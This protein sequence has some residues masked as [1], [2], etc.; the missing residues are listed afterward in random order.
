MIMLLDVIADRPASQKLTRTSPL[1][2]VPR[3][4]NRASTDWNAIREIGIVGGDPDD[5]VTASVLKLS[6]WNSE[7]TSSVQSAVDI[8][9]STPVSLH[10]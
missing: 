7:E 8:I 9:A 6:V 10:Q 2:N 3:Y 4:P 5:V 1:V